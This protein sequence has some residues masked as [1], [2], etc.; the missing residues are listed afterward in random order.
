VPEAQRF[1][2][3]LHERRLAAGLTQEQLAEHAGLGVRS[4]QDLERGSA[5]P[6]RRF[7]AYVVAAVSA[8]W[9]GGATRLETVG[10]NQPSEAVALDLAQA[11]ATLDEHLVVVLD[12]YHFVKAPAIHRA[13]ELLVE[14][15]LPRFHLVLS[16][17]ADPPLP[18]ARLRARGHLAEVRAAD[19][20]ATP[21][22]AARFCAQTMGLEIPTEVVAALQAR[23]EGWLAGLQL[24]ALSMRDHP[25]PAAFVAGSH[26]HVLDYLA[27]EVLA[28]QPEPV[29]TFLL[30]TSLL[31]RLCAS[32]CTAVTGHPQAGQL[33]EDLERSNLFLV[34]LDVAGGWFRY[35][36]LFRDVLRH[37]LQR[38]QADRL[39]EWHRRAST[40]Y[41]EHELLPE[42][43]EHALSA[44]DAQRA[45]ALLLGGGH[46][47]AGLAAS[48]YWAG[49]L[50]TLQRWLAAIPESMLYRH[51]LLSLQRAVGLLQGGR[52][53]DSAGLERCLQA[54]ERDPGDLFE[55][56]ASVRIH[57]L[58]RRG[59]AAGAVSVGE[60]VLARPPGPGY[61][62]GLV[63]IGLGYAHVLAGQ[64]RRAA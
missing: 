24:A 42:A 25:D 15:P 49:Q 37:E 22:E 26:R 44:N 62:R 61:G 28:R 40:W 29:R 36:H 48:L 31:E 60:Q 11:L 21:D 54:A 56:V 51:P 57:W 16:T 23:T 52:P 9:P 1:G 43:V 13:I 18:L 50:A 3:L 34:R 38:E 7:W 4:L 58:V 14:H 35:H 27:E 8:A 33:L 20:R 64:P 30:Q 6:L 53:E 17:R 5:R 63:L 41:A 45:C 12:D 32:L 10:S 19:L 46:P 39:F 55:G 47:L 2:S 59:D